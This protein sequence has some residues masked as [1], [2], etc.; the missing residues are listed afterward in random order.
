MVEEELFFRADGH[1]RSVFFKRN[2]TVKKGDVIAELEIDALER[3]LNAAEL[4]LQRAQVTLD[5]AKR[6][7]EFDRE[8]AQKRLEI[9]Q[10]RLDGID[11]DHNSTRAE[12]AAQAK[13]VELAQ[14]E[15][16]RIGTEVSPLLTGD[17]DAPSMRSKSSSR[18]LPSRR[19][20][21]RLTACCCRSP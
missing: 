8:V 12:V 21:H 16:D 9:A 20:S 3:D 14:L 4:E 10:I 11:A 7:L 17:L 2:E 13:E 1:I 19:S 5:E 6:N 15:L 18:P